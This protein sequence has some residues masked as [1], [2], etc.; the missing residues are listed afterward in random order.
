[1][2]CAFTRLPR[3]M[4]HW[5]NESCFSASV[6]HLRF[7]WRRHTGKDYGSS[8][9]E[10]SVYSWLPPLAQEFDLTMTL[11]AS[12]L[13]S[14]RCTAAM[15]S[16]LRRSPSGSFRTRSAGVMVSALIPCLER[17]VRASSLCSL[18]ACAAFLSVKEKQIVTLNI[19]TEQSGI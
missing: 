18:C 8:A 12:S 7:K 3:D 17:V 13:P 19:F 14:R 2:L 9:L 4:F 5:Q 1:M 11:G 15:Q 6:V 16:S 10:T